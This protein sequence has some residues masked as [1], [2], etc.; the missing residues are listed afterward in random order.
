M[1]VCVCV[2]VCVSVCWGLGGYNTCGLGVGTIQV[3]PHYKKKGRGGGRV[4]MLKEG[5]VRF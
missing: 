1:C 5:H 2:S 4:A 3:S